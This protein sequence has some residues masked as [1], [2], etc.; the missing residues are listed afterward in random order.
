MSQE[1]EEVWYQCQRCT[2]CCRWEGD[3]VLAEGE[4]EK[5]ADYLGIPLYDF[6]RD[7]TRLRGNRQGLSLVDKEGTT[8][9]IMLDGIE[10]RIQKVKPDQCTGFPNRWN[11]E[12]WREAC[13]AIPVRKP[14][15]GA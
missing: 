7:Y 14:S 15:G 4:V 12:N 5:I 1:K 8:D 9:C 6:V 13:E 3:V 10:C 11:F 2:N